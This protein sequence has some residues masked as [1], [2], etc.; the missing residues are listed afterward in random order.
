MMTEK[1]VGNGDAGQT[2][3]PVSLLGCGVCGGKMVE[4]RGRYPRDERRNVCPTCLAERMDMI[5]ELTAADYGMA[6]EAQPN[7]A[8][9]D[10]AD[11]KLKS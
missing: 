1:T 6:H 4:I 8:M 10:R 5:R 2:L 3:A 9:S 7:A 11:G